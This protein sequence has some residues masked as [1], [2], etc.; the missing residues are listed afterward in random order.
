MPVLR[1]G[2]PGVIKFNDRAAVPLCK[3]D[4]HITGETCTTYTSQNSTCQLEQHLLDRL[5]SRGSVDSRGCGS[6]RLDGGRLAGAADLE[7]ARPD[8]LHHGGRRCRHRLQ[9][10]G[11]RAV[12]S[13]P[14]TNHELDAR[15]HLNHHVISFGQ[16]QSTLLDACARWR[17]QGAQL[18]AAHASLTVAFCC[19]NIT[20]PCQRHTPSWGCG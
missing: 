5:S 1:F 19:R 7:V 3:S 10:V 9:P 6:L 17:A 12:L 4:I 8:S 20:T 2:E 14:E 18:S 16:N 15:L 13:Q 11:A